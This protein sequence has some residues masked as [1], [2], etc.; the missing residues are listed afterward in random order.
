[1]GDGHS[2][3][4]IPHPQPPSSPVRWADFAIRRASG[5]PAWGNPCLGHRGGGAMV[6]GSPKRV[7]I[8]HDETPM[9]GA[10][11][12]RVVLVPDSPVVDPRRE[13]AGTGDVS[14]DSLAELASDIAYLYRLLP[15]RGFGY[16][17]PSADRIT[18]Y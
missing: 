11:Q 2:A 13:A 16:V 18:G 9:G 8:P 6:A 4:S 5:G 14:P 3:R 17:S 7:G 15:E 1:M 10:P 12:P